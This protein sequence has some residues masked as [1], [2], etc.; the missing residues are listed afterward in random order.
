VTQV[1][2]TV[3]GAGVSIDV[4][5]RM[6]LA[7]ALRRRLGLTGTH[8]GCEH[9]VCGACTVLIDGAAARSCLV[10][11]VQ[12]Q[13][14][15]VLTVESLGRAD[16]LHPLQAAFRRHHGLQ[17]G[18]CTPGFLMTSYELLKD[19]PPP[20]GELVPDELSGVLCR[21]TG[22]Q[23]VVQAVQDVARE[24]PEGLPPPGNL[25]RPLI[26]TGGPAAAESTEAPPEDETDG[27]VHP[28]EF[29]LSPPQGEP[30]A[31]V[32]VE[33]A[34][35]PTA[36]EAWELLSDFPRVSRCIPG[37]EL[38]GEF[39]DDMYTAQAQLQVGPMR[40]R[41]KGAA[42]VLERNEEARTL[43]A[44][45][46]GRDPTGDSVRADLTLRADAREDGGA[47]IVASAR[48]F[49][50]GRAAQFGRTV[51]G[52]VSRQLFE[53]FGSCVDRTLTTG[54]VVEPTQLRGGGLA[55]QLLRGRLVGLR[56]RLLQRVRRLRS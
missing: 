25:G 23:G 28:S 1:D 33:T 13:G 35:E 49:L 52:D 54:E 21:C 43:R 6:T 31:V 4:P 17:C 16:D 55:W 29:D 10:F 47:L 3:N 53:Q 5:P 26:V 27:R 11:C 19:G 42:Q 14:A 8:V 45:A 46:A 38:T 18:F 22:Y 24:H 30:N 51:V 2:F 15:E 41:F 56:D 20:D 34:I 48:L 7:D 50:A 9:G 37:V 39:P 40:F 12:V 32:E 44:V 36:D